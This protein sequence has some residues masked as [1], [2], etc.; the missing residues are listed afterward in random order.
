MQGLD[1]GKKQGWFIVYGSALTF[2]R[3]YFGTLAVAK[4]MA[5]VRD[6]YAQV[7]YDGDEFEYAIEG[8]RRHITKHMQKLENI[9]PAKILGAYAVVAFNDAD[10]PDTVELMTWPQIQKAWSKG[11][12]SNPARADFPDQ[13]AL[14]TV[15]N[16]AL[17]LHINSSD[18]NHLLLEAFNQDAAQ[19]AE[20]DI[21]VEAQERG[22]RGYI[23][24]DAEEAP[25]GELEGG[26]ETPETASRGRRE[27]EQESAF[28]EEAPPF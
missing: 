14:R 22:N 21:E 28:A 15:L 10:R 8:G 16:R 23:D 25:A 24:I 27:A 2:Q 6:A 4:R 11:S 18:D 20:D 3:S 1:V 26:E 5:D 13:M 19:Q 7:I 17:K 9:D 12:G